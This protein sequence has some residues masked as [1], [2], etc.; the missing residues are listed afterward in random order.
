VKQVV[1]MQQPRI[2]AAHVERFVDALAR[3]DRKAA[4]RQALG[5]LEAGAPVEASPAV[6]AG[7]LVIGAMDG[8]LYCFGAK[9]S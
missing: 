6:G 8:T 5:L 3:R 7:R 1:V 4:A 9:G 2:T